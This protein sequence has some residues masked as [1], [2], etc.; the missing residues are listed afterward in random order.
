MALSLS[1]IPS[2][3]SESSPWGEGWSATGI[4]SMR[5]SPLGMR[6]MG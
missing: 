6:T 5:Q 4:P 3:S 1:S 2:H